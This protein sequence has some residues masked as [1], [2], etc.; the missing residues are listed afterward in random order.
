[1]KKLTIT[2]QSSGQRL[3]KFLTGLYPNYSRA[4]LQKQ[5]KEGQI[6]VNQE[7]KKPSYTLKENDEIKTEIIAPPEISLEPDP[8]IKLKIIYEDDD[9]IVVDKPA[10]LTVHPSATQKNKTLINALLSR[11]PLL[12]DVGDDPL[13][14]GLVHR[15]D[16]DTSGLMIVAKNNSAFE[17]LKKQFQERKVIK[18]YLALVVGKPKQPSGEIKTFIT[19][20]KSDPT[21][22]KVLLKSYFKSTRSLT[23]TS[24][25]EAI[26]HYNVLREFR[27]FTLLETIPKTGRMHQI[28]V[29]LAWLG[30]PVAGDKKYG[31]RKGF[32]SKS[33]ERQF[34]HASELTITLPNG[35][36]KTF[37]S[38]LPS[39]LS[40][41]LQTLEKN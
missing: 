32:T 37:T 2:K 34:L 19:R 12:K 6:L 4:Y 7:K 3:D 41:I 39:D 27:D 26:T 13:R 17:W 8:T 33:L 25:R 40:T 1:M 11:Y 30:C 21:K 24:A 31:P 16:K 9:V 10:G 20:S 36:K 5:I 29:H 38:S 35:Q 14:P 15:L 28:R 23:S 22:Q 18:K